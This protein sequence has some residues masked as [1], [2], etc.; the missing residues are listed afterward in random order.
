MPPKR[1][2]VYLEPFFDEERLPRST[3]YRR[4]HADRS[5]PEECDGS[6]M[7]DAPT[8]DEHYASS[9]SSL[10]PPPSIN[11]ENAPSASCS[12][13]YV[14]SEDDCEVYDLLNKESDYDPAGR[15]SFPDSDFSADDIATL[16]MDFAVKSGLSWTQIES[17]MKFVGF[18]L[19]RDD[20]PDTKFLFKNFAGISLNTLTRTALTVLLMHRL[21]HLC[22]IW[23][24]IMATLGAAG[25]CTQ[26]NPL[27]GQSS[28]LPVPLPFPTEPRTL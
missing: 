24:N 26:E 28:T 9:T 14:P 2:K 17:L 21:V 15:A 23:C 11:P 6:P 10:N 5:A 8:E 1:R 4:S 13:F 20:L 12:S 27:K 16:V 7:S 19:K 22:K 3:E 25:A 18:I